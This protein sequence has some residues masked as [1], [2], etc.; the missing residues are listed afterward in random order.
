MRVLFSARRARAA[1][2]HEL[3]CE[4]GDDQSETCDCSTTDV[5]T[6]D[7]SQDSTRGAVDVVVLI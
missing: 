7:H 3:V 1:A 5:T 2:A 6:V 4:R